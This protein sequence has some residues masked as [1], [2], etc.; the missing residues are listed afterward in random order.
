[1]IGGGERGW[2]STRTP[3]RSTPEFGLGARSRPPGDGVWRAIR[4]PDWWSRWERTA[5]TSRPSWRA[6]VS[7]FLAWSES[8]P[9]RRPSGRSLKGRTAWSLPPLNRV[10]SGNPLVHRTSHPLRFGWF[11]PELQQKFASGRKILIDDHH[12]SGRRSR[13]FTKCP[14]RAGRPRRTELS[15]PAGPDREERYTAVCGPWAV[16][17]GFGPGKRPGLLLGP[18]SDHSRRRMVSARAAEAMWR[19]YRSPGRSGRAGLGP[20]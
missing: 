16:A 8:N 1:V 12:D 15:A 13:R 10:I 5:R 6:C 11:A 4:H 7:E 17:G 9:L 20:G 14:G 19:R 18:Y 3:A 2:R